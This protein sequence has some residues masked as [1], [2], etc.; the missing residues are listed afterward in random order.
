MNAQISVLVIYV[1][2]IINLLLYNLHDLPLTHHR[3]KIERYLNKGKFGLA[4]R[5]FSRK[6]KQM[7]FA[8]LVRSS[9]TQMI[10]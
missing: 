2:A 9:R 8:S 10:F 5:H 6:R 4:K 3:N 1:E 7:L